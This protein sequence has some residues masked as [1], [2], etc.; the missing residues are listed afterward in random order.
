MQ[1]ILYLLLLTAFSFSLEA[2]SKKIILASF[3]TEQR[4][5]AMIASLPQRSPSLYKLSQKYDFDIKIRVSG[6]YYIL[7][8]EV[9]RDKKVLDTAFK[10]VKKRFKGSYITNYKE[11]E[12]LKVEKKVEKKV[13][14]KEIILEIQKVIPKIKIM[15]K[16]IT[17]EKEIVENIKVEPSDSMSRTKEK[18]LM[19]YEEYKTYFSWY[20]IVI[21]FI[22]S[23]LAYYYIKFK[24]I[25]DEY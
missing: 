23:I 13:V 4:A 15:P 1:R 8:A 20:Y 3:S 7:V 10:S 19:F 2:Y 6:K 11:I 9:F 21:F 16:E 18:A 14:K 17:K 5:D 12:T 25:Y 24:R 22:L